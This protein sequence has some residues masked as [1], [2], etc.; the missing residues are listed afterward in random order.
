MQERAKL[1]ESV[2]KDRDYLEWFQ[3]KSAER[4]SLEKTQFYPIWLSKETKEK[5]KNRKQNG[6]SYEDII[7]RLLEK[8]SEEER[9]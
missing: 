1:G 9:K 6:E 2:V 5:L 3:N 8:E 7:N 4:E